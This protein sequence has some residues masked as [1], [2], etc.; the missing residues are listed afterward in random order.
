[1]WNCYERLLANE[2]QEMVKLCSVSRS[3]LATARETPTRAA[4]VRS[5]VG[6]NQQKLTGERWMIFDNSNSPPEVASRRA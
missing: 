2:C 5:L 6:T 3:A 1:M 4:S